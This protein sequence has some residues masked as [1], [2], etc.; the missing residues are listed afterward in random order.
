MGAAGRHRPGTPAPAPP[1]SRRQ[2]ISAASTNIWNKHLAEISQRV[3]V[4]V[5]ALLILEAAG[6]HGSPLLIVPGNGVLMPLNVRAR[7]ELRRKHLGLSAPK[8]AQPL[9]LS[10]LVAM[11]A[12]P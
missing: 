10:A 5:I 6:R 8:L 3:S 4:S 7:A 11:P 2:L 12:T 9:R 1:R